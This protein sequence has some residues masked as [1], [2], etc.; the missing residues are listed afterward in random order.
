MNDSKDIKPTLSTVFD[1]AAKAGAVL[2]DNP[3]LESD[4][5]RAIIVNAV[6]E[7]LKPFLQALM[8]DLHELN[9]NGT[10]ITSLAEFYALIG[11]DNT[12]TTTN[13]DVH[14]LMPHFDPNLTYPMSRDWKD[15]D[16]SAVSCANNK[17]GKCVTPSLAVIDANGRCTGFHLNLKPIT[18]Q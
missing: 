2:A 9:V 7:R 14:G 13:N 6:L 4:I 15:I 8:S 3:A 12:M 18:R 11:G 17:A 1:S 10:Y 5:N 16:C